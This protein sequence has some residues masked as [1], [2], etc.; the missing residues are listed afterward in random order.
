MSDLVGRHLK[1][2]LCGR[3]ED[4]IRFVLLAASSS[5]TRRDHAGERL[6]A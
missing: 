5:G 1:P 3:L 6:T 2:L 4:K